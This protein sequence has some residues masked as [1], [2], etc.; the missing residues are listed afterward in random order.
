M[1][2]VG[3]GLWVRVGVRV[4]MLVEVRVRLGE[5]GGEVGGCRISTADRK[6]V[7]LPVEGCAEGMAHMCWSC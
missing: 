1:R 2:V 7:A 6:S 4:G 3:S 5:D